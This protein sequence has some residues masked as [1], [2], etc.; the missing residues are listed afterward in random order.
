MLI[1]PSRFRLGASAVIGGGGVAGYTQWRVICDS[2][3]GPTFGIAELSMATA[4][5]GANIATGQTYSDS[6]HFDINSI[7]DKAFD[8]NLATAFVAALAAAGVGE[9]IQ[10]TF[11]T[12]KTILEIGITARDAGSG[13]TNQAPRT[14]RL[15]YNNGVWTNAFSFTTGVW[16][17]ASEVRKF[18]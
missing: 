17:T 6:S 18:S 16:S 1:V 5:S 12:P 2:T 8:S 15:Q 10:V 9:W 13:A 3:D 4:I 11:G 7:A 14:G